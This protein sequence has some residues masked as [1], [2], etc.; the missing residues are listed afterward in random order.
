MNN[1]LKTNLFSSI[2]IL[3]LLAGNIYMSMQYISVVKELQKI[4]S[5]DTASESVKASVV[6]TEVLDVVLNTRPTTPDDR[7]KLENDIRQL[8]D[9]AITAQWET[10]VASKDAKT[11]Q[12][13]VLKIVGM[14]ED[15]MSVR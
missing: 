3:I 15:K 8:K 2:L 12:A 1:F 14:L 6:L 10:L 5:S 13:A 7:I 9:P 4:K 11:S